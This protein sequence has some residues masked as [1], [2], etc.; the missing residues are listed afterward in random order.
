MLIY[1]ET[2][3][4]PWKLSVNE[5]PFFTTSSFGTLFNTWFTYYTRQVADWFMLELAKSYF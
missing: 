3:K 2:Q 4:I 1:L 5:Q